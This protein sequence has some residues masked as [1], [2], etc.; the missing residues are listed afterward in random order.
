MLRPMIGYRWRLEA[1]TAVRDCALP[2][3]G[4][5]TWFNA[6]EEPVHDRSA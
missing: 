1:S 2:T 6:D 5:Q 3:V 4:A